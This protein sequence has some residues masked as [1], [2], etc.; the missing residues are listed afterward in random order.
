[1]FLLD[2]Y[3]CVI[4][5]LKIT[6]FFEKVRKVKETGNY[7]CEI[8]NYTTKFREINKS[9]SRKYAKY[10]QNHSTEFRR[11]SANFL[12]ISSNFVFREITRYPFHGHPI[13]QAVLRP[14]FQDQKCQ[15][16]GFHWDQNTPFFIATSKSHTSVQWMDQWNP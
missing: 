2:I 1:M 14:N 8:R 13:C 3:L 6:P 16:Q 7:F 10:W 9:I 15:S 4:I 11:N 12:L 5:S